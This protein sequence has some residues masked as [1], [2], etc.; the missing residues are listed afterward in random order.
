[1]LEKLKS[2]VKP[3]SNWA[4]FTA[5]VIGAFFIGYYYPTM[6]KSIHDEPKVIDLKTVDR[7]S[8][9]VTDRGEMLILD[10][11]NGSFEVYDEQVGLAVFKAYGARITTTQLK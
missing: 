3:I 6:M 10:R 9:S 11:M 2:L 5:S 1:M 4:L 7:C 8:V